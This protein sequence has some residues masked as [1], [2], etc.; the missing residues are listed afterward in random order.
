MR[1]FCPWIPTRLLVLLCI[2]VN[3]KCISSFSPTL[4]INHDVATHVNKIINNPNDRQHK[5]CMVSGSITNEVPTGKVVVIRHLYRF[6]PT[7]MSVENKY[8][9]EE[10][11]YFTVGQDRSLEPL[12]DKSI[13]FR[14][15]ESFDE[16]GGVAS[17]GPAL[18]TLQGLKDGGSVLESCYAMALYSMENPAI[19]GGV[20][21]DLEARDLRVC[22]VPILGGTDWLSP[23]SL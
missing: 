7:Q 5:L 18:Y 6:S 20:R 21:L 9:I 12:G 19:V 17:V 13:I 14:G 16:N 11:Q 10:R 1:S 3:L 2:H 8:A 22:V 23:S 15:N 4:A